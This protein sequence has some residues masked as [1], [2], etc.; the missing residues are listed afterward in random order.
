MNLNTIVAIQFP[1]LG[2]K[3]NKNQAW[4]GTLTDG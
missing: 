4:N 1:K 3:G 2:N